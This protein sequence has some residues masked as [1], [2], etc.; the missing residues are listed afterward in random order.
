MN[1]N[2]TL[3]NADQINH[4]GI[5]SR[6]SFSKFLERVQQ[7]AEREKTGRKNLSEFIQDRVEK[8]PHWLE[9]PN[10]F[11]LQPYDGLLELI[12]T[13][14][15]SPFEDE[16]EIQWGLGLPFV[17][18]VFYGTKG[19]YQF[20][21]RKASGQ[22]RVVTKPE[23]EVEMRVRQL[24]AVYSFI[25][26]HFYRFPEFS[27]FNF[28]YAVDQGTDGVHYMRA[29]LD[30]SFVTVHAKESLPTLDLTHLRLKQLDADSLDFLQTRLPLSSFYFEGFSILT[31]RDA[32]FEYVMDEI[33]N[34]L[35]HQ[36]KDRVA[37]I[38]NVLWLFK[39]LI[40]DKQVE[41][42]VLPL[43]QLNG[44]LAVPYSSTN[45]LSLL[46]KFGVDSEVTEDA[47]K[48]ELDSY[49]KQPRLLVIKK[50]EESQ[51]RT[52][53]HEII[54]PTPF[55]ALT[56]VP[57]FHNHD[58]V[59]VLEAYTYHGYG[60][61]EQCLGRVTLALPLLSQLLKKGMEEFEGVIR[62]VMNEGFTSIQKA[63]EWKFKE[64]AWH[65]LR[66]F[67]SDFA[68]HEV[69]KVS[70]EQLYPLYGAVDI[71]NSTVE[72]NQALKLDLQKQMMQLQ[73][74]ISD[75]CQNTTDENWGETKLQ[76][77]EWLTRLAGPFS[78]ALEN[79]MDKFL[80][81]DIHP[82]LEQLRQSSPEKSKAIDAYLSALDRT[83]RGIQQHRQALED[84]I[85]LINRTLATHF[86]K[87]K[88]QLSERFP[89]YFETFRTDGLEYDVYVGRS[90][91]PDH[92]FDG[93]VV[94]D[95]RLMQLSSMAEVVQLMHELLAQMPVPLQTTQLI[96]VHANPIDISFRND[97]KRFGV[98]GA[99]NIRYEIL[100]KRI[101]KVHVNHTGERLTQPGK[102]AIVYYDDQMADEYKVY[103]NTLQQ[104]G[105]LANDVEFLELEELQGVN[106]LK[107]LRVGVPL[108]ASKSQ[109]QD[110]T[111]TEAILQ[112]L[113]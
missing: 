2:F 31:S 70:F 69:G 59:S 106:G 66:Q 38:V 88:A 99:Y 101:D 16:E 110:E 14:L 97:E 41:F 76:C 102:I 95:F 39:L 80:Q 107:A 56:L 54:E 105:K 112:N 22:Y 91:A 96:F 10:I 50:D 90:I 87:L 46:T 75:L 62:E 48:A 86:V 65:H 55:K 28:I 30:L 100:K 49:K 27:K 4:Y 25:L 58:L 1:R 98:E 45:P 52:L 13:L 85:Q 7:L 43:P 51:N 92:E 83:G 79:N 103:F 32:S 36:G 35:A 60:L 57:I 77:E 42:A 64:A 11:D 93:S 47:F 82:R 21:E 12:Y 3:L 20:I 15:V 109:S 17:P 29:E 61:G 24:R 53:L 6:L 81:Q 9:S 111:Q 8:N 40:A 74:I 67:G 63:V 89:S 68:K 26:H 108:R 78:S 5:D 84:S 34:A 71:R 33:K 44:R 23:D 18:S 113:P 19:I 94:K 37:T 72:R 104:Q 73:S